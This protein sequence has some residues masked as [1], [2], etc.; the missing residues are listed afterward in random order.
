MLALSNLATLLVSFALA[1]DASRNAKPTPDLGSSFAVYPG[2]DMDNGSSSTISNVTE[3]ACMQACGAST[4]CTAYAYGPYPS[5][6]SAGATC[7]LKD[8]LDLSKF[9]QQPDADISTG[10][11]GACENFKPV[12]PTQCYTIA[13]A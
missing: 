9:K 10:I 5:F 11:I 6:R 3:Q 8:S 12:G 13:V 4:S 2:W 1:T 7:F